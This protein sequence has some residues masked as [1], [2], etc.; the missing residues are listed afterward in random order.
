MIIL[1]GVDKVG[2]SSLAKAL[3][4]HLRDHEV[5]HCEV[6]PP[7][8]SVFDYQMR[9]IGKKRKLIVDRLH[10]SEYA[11]GETYRGGC[12]YTVQQWA[13]MEEILAERG[14]RII[15]LSDALSLVKERWEK[16]EKQFDVAGLVRLNTFFFDLFYD[17]GSRLSV[18][19][20]ININWRD[21]F[22][23]DGT[24]R[25]ISNDSGVKVIA[26]YAAGGDAP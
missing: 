4:R 25:M 2:K 26:E 19:P 14:A 17:R 23:P 24:E 11:Y 22:N 20:R 3:A 9:M 15:L 12:G 16:E 21:V 5:V 8:E 10:W 7:G 1:E 6:P 13:A 18:L